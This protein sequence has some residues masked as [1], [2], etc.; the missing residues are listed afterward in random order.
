MRG[1]LAVMVAIAS[2]ATGAE[3]G[4]K[5]KSSWKPP[6]ASPV[7]FRGQKVAAVVMLSDEKTRVGI[8]DELAYALRSRGVE[9][10]AAHTLVPPGEMKDKERARARLDEA[11]VA[12]A[13]VLRSVNK[14]QELSETPGSYWVTNYYSF[15]DFYGWGWG[16]IYDPGYV[17]MDN[18]FWVET[19][20][21]DVKANKLLWAA[22]SETKNPK[23]ADEFMSDL[24][25]AAAKQ[26]Q[27]EGLVRK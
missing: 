4:T 23:R 24:V 26:L 6:D 25:S 10:V 13:V 15:T 12:G 20:V 1:R 2:I 3:A 7:N 16:G 17:K 5:F 14:T 21:F 18:V 9:G 22:L 8:E 11:G 27:K 19:L